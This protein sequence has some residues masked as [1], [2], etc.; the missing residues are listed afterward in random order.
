[1]AIKTKVLSLLVPASGLLLGACD[2]P[3]MD[4]SQETLATSTADLVATKGDSVLATK[5]GAVG[6]G[7]GVPLAPNS[8]SCTDKYVGF[9][10]YTMIDCTPPALGGTATELARVAASPALAVSPASPVASLAAVDSGFA[11]GSTLS[12]FCRILGGPWYTEVKTTESCIMGVPDFSTLAIL[13]A[14]QPFST[15]WNGDLGDMPPPFNPNI[16][17]F[18]G[19]V[20]ECC[21]GFISCP[22]G[23][24][25]PH[26]FSCNNNGPPP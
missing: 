23:R 13:S 14:P 1:M 12:P 26:G 16:F 10:V 17:A 19:S 11:T 25:L 6:S 20:C 3:P 15:S 8:R 2:V 21:P 4:P 18:A 7:G 5:A 24:C 9:M 22:D